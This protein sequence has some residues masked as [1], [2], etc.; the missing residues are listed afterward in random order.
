MLHKEFE[1]LGYSAEN[2]KYVPHL[3]MMR[4]KGNE[5]L[6]PL[7]NFIKYDFAHEEFKL[8]SISLYKSELKRSGSVYSKIYII[9][10]YSEE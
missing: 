2:R 8:K 5:N 1:K 7:N 3:T 9:K 10:I 4:L 6:E